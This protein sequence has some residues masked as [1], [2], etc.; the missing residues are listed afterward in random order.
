MVPQAELEQML[1]S[2]LKARSVCLQ[3]LQEYSQRIQN[4]EFITSK[5]CVWDG[6]ARDAERQLTK[7][8]DT[9]RKYLK[10]A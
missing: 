3:H 5:D 9:L 7:T 6:Y 8:I 4:G 1:N 10:N 2:T